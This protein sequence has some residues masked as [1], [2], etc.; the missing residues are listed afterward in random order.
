MSC[1][2]L[3]PTMKFAG[4]ELGMTRHASNHWGLR[5]AWE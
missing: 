3:A 2:T 4:M 1:E 5:C